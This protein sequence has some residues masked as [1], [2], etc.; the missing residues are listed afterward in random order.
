MEVN[1]WVIIASRNQ[2]KIFNRRNRQKPLKW[3]S[4]LKNPDRPSKNEFINN[5]E[6]EIA[7]TSG[8]VTKRFARKIADRLKVGADQHAFKKLYIFAEPHLLGCIKNEIP[9]CM[10]N[11]IIEW[12]AKDLEKATAQEIT[13]RVS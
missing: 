3:M 13:E 9:K 7:L 11:I 2:A 1:E 10:K 6:P 12:I 8:Q 4:T 5:S